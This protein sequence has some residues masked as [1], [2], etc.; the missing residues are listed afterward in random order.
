[1]VMSFVLT[2][3]LSACGSNAE[4]KA[5]PKT[6]AIE[7]SAFPESPTPSSFGGTSYSSVKELI[8][9]MGD[10]GVTCEGIKI[11][12]PP[13]TSIADFGLCFIDGALEFETDIYVFEDTSSRDLW[14]NSFADYP[15]IH[16]LLGEN[17]FI[18]SGSVEELTRVQRA[19]GGTI[20]P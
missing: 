6:P 14:H 1:M 20:D 13:Q 4:P 7:R 19:V 16:T 10:G 2:V 18:T 8:A 11:L 5:T 12:K 9:S 17:W 15:D 3:E